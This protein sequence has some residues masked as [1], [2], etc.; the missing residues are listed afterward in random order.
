[1]SEFRDP[2]GGDAPP[3]TARP[4]GP[5]TR[6]PATS[7][8]TATPPPPPPAQPAAASPPAHATGA[9]S[10]WRQQVHRA[11]RFL[12]LASVGLGAPLATTI[13]LYRFVNPPT[14]MVIL[15][16]RLTGTP[17][18]RTWIPLDRISSNLV[19]AVIMSE[20][21]GFCRHHG[22]DWRE[23]MAAIETSK[24]GIA[25]G[26]STISM[27]T[28]KNLFLWNAKSFVRKGIEIPTAIVAD[29]IWPK[30]RMLEI[31]LN[32]A[33]WGP[34]IFGAEAAARAHFN[35]SASRLTEAEAALLAV[36]LPN[37]V[38]R[39]SGD[40]GAL[41]RR[42]AQRIQVRMRSVGDRADC[43]LRRGKA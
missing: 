1:M 9:T 29:F 28:V 36:A 40:P 19:R 26:A 22:V 35:K 2:H 25:R 21:S 3:P 23:L 37:P 41:Q 31:Y 6:A 20:D 39:D 8:R 7:R 18:T 32:I 5:P 30:A 11:L 16:Q 42:L 14:S 4:T 15:A 10:S 27:Q 17:I 24:D 33:E 13:V 43:V 38:A 34:G 12:L